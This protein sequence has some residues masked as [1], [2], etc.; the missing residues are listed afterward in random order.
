MTKEVKCLSEALE[1]AK[2]ADEIQRIYRVE[3]ARINSLITTKNAEET[4]LLTRLL[5]ERDAPR[6]VSKGVLVGLAEA[7]EKR[8]EKAIEERVKAVHKNWNNQCRKCKEAEKG[9]VLIDHKRFEDHLAER[10]KRFQA[11]NKLA[12]WGKKDATEDEKLARI[13][14]HRVREEIAFL[15]EVSK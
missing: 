12:H 11:Y 10:Q 2:T 5:N 7:D 14:Y 4:K 13:G 9:K 8:E 3:N 15:K 6:W 1:Q